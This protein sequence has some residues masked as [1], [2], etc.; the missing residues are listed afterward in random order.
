MTPGTPEA[1]RYKGGR[2]RGR[3]LALQALFELEMT[4]HATEQALA[5]RLDEGTSPPR[6]EEFTRTLVLGTWACRDE[7]DRY[8]ARAAPQWPV[9]QLPVVE[10]SILRLAIYE[11]CFDNKTPPRAAINEAVELAKAYGGENSSRFVNGVLG[12]VASERD[13][14]GNVRGRVDL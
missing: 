13:K 8:I 10:K 14:G 4:D 9:D 1:G 12:F 11:L 2:R 7:L 3:E 5:D 6:Y